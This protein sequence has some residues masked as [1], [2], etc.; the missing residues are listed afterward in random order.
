[1]RRGLLQ[2]LVD[3]KTFGEVASV[4]EAWGRKKLRRRGGGNE[5]QWRTRSRASSLH[6]ELRGLKLKK[7]EEGTG[8]EGQDQGSCTTTSAV[9]HVSRGDDRRHP[10]CWA[11]ENLRTKPGASVEEDP[12]FRRGLKS[13]V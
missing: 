11:I 7:G 10:R 3:L 1:M 13:K 6:L 4:K 2:H 5:V 8:I 9:L 12:K